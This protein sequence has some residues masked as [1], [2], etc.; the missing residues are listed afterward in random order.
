[1]TSPETW[2]TFAHNQAEGEL[3]QQ[4]LREDGIP[5]ILKRS[6]GFDVPDFL[7]AGPRDVFVPAEFE[8]R[9]A[10]LMR[11]TGY[12]SESNAK[13]GVAPW[14]VLASL[15]GGIGLIILIGFLFT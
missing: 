5:S 4:I 7:A 15:F 8:E 13:P 12:L 11:E 14:V 6:A 10:A 3:I 1:M 9:A 2:V